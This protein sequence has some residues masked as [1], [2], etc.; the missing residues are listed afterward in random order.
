MVSYH[1]TSAAPCAGALLTCSS[2]AVRINGFRTLYAQLRVLNN[3]PGLQWLYADNFTAPV[4]VWLWRIAL[5]CAGE[6]SD[7]HSAERT[8]TAG[9]SC[10]SPVSIKPQSSQD[11]ATKAR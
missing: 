7:L 10:I 5:S 9:C 4:R 8:P 6:Q 11:S 1:C 3:L 2:S